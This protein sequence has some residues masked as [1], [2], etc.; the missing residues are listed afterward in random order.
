V[1]RVEYRPSPQAG[2]SEQV[3]L[4]RWLEAIGQLD[5]PSR[6]LPLEV[7]ADVVASALGVGDRPAPTLRRFG[8]RLG[9]DGWTLPVLSASV[10]QLAGID[11]VAAARFDHFDTGIA[12]AEGWTEGARATAGV[13]GC[14][15]PLTGLV[16]LPVLRIRLEQ[17]YDQCAALGVPAEQAYRLVVIDCAAGRQ[18]PFVRDATHV[19][20]A[21]HL[22][23][24]FTSGETLCATGS[25]RLL[26]LTAM[27]RS[28]PTQVVVLLEG[29][30]ATPLLHQA[31]V[32]AWIEPLPA[33]PSDISAFLADVSG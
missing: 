3:L 17:V 28:L 11:T 10:G 4:D 27:T 24:A 30:Q 15:D 18:P 20:A 29:L 14:L 1:G 12:L 2:S 25:G 8:R 5:V 9:A 7:F 23:R 6:A 26:V 19:V 22:R 21:E 32:L 13:D 31:P 16:R 33:D